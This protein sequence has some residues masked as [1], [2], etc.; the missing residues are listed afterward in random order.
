VTEAS[1]ARAVAGVWAAHIGLDRM[2]GYGLKYAAGFGYTHLGRIG[3]EAR[4]ER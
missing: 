3:R 2:L 4:T 1:Q